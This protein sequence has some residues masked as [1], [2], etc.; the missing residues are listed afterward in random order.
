[1]IP[2][3]SLRAHNHYL[4]TPV[5]GVSVALSWPL[6]ALHAHRLFFFFKWQDIHIPKEEKT[7]TRIQII[8][9]LCMC[10]MF[11]LALCITHVKI[12]FISLCIK[13]MNFSRGF[14][15]NEPC[16]LFFLTHRTSKLR[17]P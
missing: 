16:S 10:C 15:V 17:N 3:T 6:Q 5:P 12:A 11:C 8:V 14:E 1:M 2:I 9:F 4:L 7:K 13:P